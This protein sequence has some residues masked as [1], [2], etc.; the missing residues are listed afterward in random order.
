[1][2]YNNLKIDLN[3][4]F[5]CN[6]DLSKNYD[7]GDTT[8]RLASRSNISFVNSR[9]QHS[10]STPKHGSTLVLGL[11]PTPTTYSNDFCSGI[12]R[13]KKQADEDSVLELSLSYNS[14]ASKSHLNRFSNHYSGSFEANNGF[15]ISVFDEGATSAK[16]SGGYIPSLLLAPRIS[17]TTSKTLLQRF[18]LS[19]HG[20]KSDHGCPSESSVVSG[21]S[22]GTTSGQTESF[23]P[24]GGRRRC[25]HPTGCSN[26][27]RGKWDFC[28]K[29]GGGKRCVV[30]GC[31]RSA[32]LQPGLCISHGG[33]RRCWFHGC[34][35]GAQ[36]STNYCKAHGGG[37]RCVFSG[38]TTGAEGSTQLCKSHGG[39]KR[40]LYEGG[41]ICPKSVH[42][43]TNFCVMHG[44]GK[45]CVVAGCTKSARGRTHCCVT[46]GGGKRCK[47]E[48]CTKCAQ[49]STDFCKGHGGGRRCG[50]VGGGGEG[51]CEKFARGK[52]GLCMAHGTMVQVNEGGIGPQLFHGVVAKSASDNNSLSGVSV[53]SSSIGW[54]ERPVKRRQLIPPQVLVPSSMKTWAFSSFT[55][56]HKEG[57]A[58]DVMVPEGRVHGG[59]LLSLLGGSLKDAVIDRI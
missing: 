35:K 55:P 17:S 43:G 19:E 9:E 27:A 53:V 28:I 32:E 48:N 39:G 14:N 3:A 41:G 42:G 46:H 23:I 6:D 5:V 31:S 50:W 15:G 16:K 2:V 20:E 1:M 34:T 13:N 44:G 37:K 18:E 24:P 59:S 38:C 36:G 52:G 7:Y 33:G 54:L 57:D 58:S 10:K 26:A 49:G 47:F 29:H 25:R 22:T 21:Y 12:N 51:K 4:A 30:E 40:C 8:L 56:N 11:G 45:R